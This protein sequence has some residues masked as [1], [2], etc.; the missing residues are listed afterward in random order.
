MLSRLKLGF[1]VAALVKD[2]GVRAWKP[3]VSRGRGH[4][5]GWGGLIGH[6]R[7]SGASGVQ[8]GD[9]STLPQFIPQ[10]LLMG[11]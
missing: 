7:V 5:Y 9:A 1:G 10:H 2:V 8:E 4:D 11:A 6:V 3:S